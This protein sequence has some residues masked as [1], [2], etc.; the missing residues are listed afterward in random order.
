MVVENATARLKNKW[1]R[2]KKI[3]TA[4]VGRANEIIR[5]SIILHNYTIK[6]D[7]ITDRSDG[8]ALPLPLHATAELKRES[9]ARYLS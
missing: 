4:T 9:I 5:C 7:T 3:Y 1:R 8:V 6:Y 2:L